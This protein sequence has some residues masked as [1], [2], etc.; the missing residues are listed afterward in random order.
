MLKNLRLGE[1]WLKRRRQ[2]VPARRGRKG[3]NG[4]V[5]LWAIGSTKVFI[6]LFGIIE[7]KQERWSIFDVQWKRK[8]LFA[9][10]SQLLSVETEFTLK[11]IVLV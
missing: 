8:N 4:R 10:Y 2:D 5:M 7:E 1:I 3:K 11:G 6:E 9:G